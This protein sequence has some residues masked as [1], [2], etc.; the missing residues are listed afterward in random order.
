MYINLEAK[1]RLRLQDHL[2]KV[3][4]LCSSPFTLCKIITILVCQRMKS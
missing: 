3:L 1:S 2:M 4:K